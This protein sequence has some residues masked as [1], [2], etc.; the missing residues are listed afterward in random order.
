MKAAAVPR[1]EREFP[2]EARRSARNG[3]I[4]HERRRWCDTEDNPT[5]EDWAL[6]Q[7]LQASGVCPR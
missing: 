6:P 1:I 2:F 7:E 3:P 5:N 4:E